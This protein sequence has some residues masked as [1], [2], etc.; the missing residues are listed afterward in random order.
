MSELHTFD[1]EDLSIEVEECEDFYDGTHYRDYSITIKA[2]AF[3][4]YRADIQH[5]ALS[6]EVEIEVS[7]RH[8]VT[9]EEAFWEQADYKYAESRA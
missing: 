4:L 1:L 9:A 5:S 7:T 6:P 8:T 2:K 3:D